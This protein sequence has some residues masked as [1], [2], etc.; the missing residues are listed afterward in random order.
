MAFVL[1]CLVQ[2]VVGVFVIW[3]PTAIFILMPAWAA[4]RRSPGLYRWLWH[5]RLLGPM[6]RYW[7]T[8][9]SVSRRS[10]GSATWMVTLNG[11]LLALTE[12]PRWTAALACICM[13]CAVVWL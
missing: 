11:A 1:P 7:A 2:G 5:H 12:A 9:G 3:L 10:T 8:G 4:A 6:L 13:V